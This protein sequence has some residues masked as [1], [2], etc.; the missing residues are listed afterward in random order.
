[1]STCCPQ[2]FPQGV[3][4]VIHR[5][6]IKLSTGLWITFRFSGQTV[7]GR[8]LCEIFARFPRN[9][10]AAARNFFFSRLDR[11]DQPNKTFYTATDQN[12]AAVGCRDGSVYRRFPWSGWSGHRVVTRQDPRSTIWVHLAVRPCVSIRESCLPLSGGLLPPG[13]RP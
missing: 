11:F 10:S 13:Y 6:W 5:V 1:M 12:M 2:A 7:F 9:R 4:K 3:D 8:N